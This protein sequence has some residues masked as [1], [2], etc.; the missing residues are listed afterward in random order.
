MACIELA[1][2]KCPLAVLPRL[3]PVDGTQPHDKRALRDPGRETL[4]ETC[5]ED[6]TH[7]EEVPV[8]DVVV[9][10]GSIPPSV[11]RAEKEVALGGMEVAARGIHP[12][13]PARG[14]ELLPGGE[15]QGVAAELGD[16]PGRERLPPIGPVEVEFVVGKVRGLGE[17]L[18]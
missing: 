6:R 12:E 9:H 14:A 17:L 2:A 18:E 3:P 8:R 10:T 1:V 13:R 4:P 11:H 16:G 7:L 5:W 15:P